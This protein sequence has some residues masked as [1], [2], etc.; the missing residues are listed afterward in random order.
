MDY[1]AQVNF[2]GYKTIGQNVYAEFLDPLSGQSFL[3]NKSEC[4]ARLRNLKTNALT[5]IQTEMA[6]DHWPDTGS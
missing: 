2:L 5:S 4:L 1:Q 3:L 6:L